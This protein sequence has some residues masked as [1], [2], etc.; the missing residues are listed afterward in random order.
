MK[1]RKMLSCFL[2]AA[3]LMT[4]LTGCGK[5][6]EENGGL[7]EQERGRY[8]E[9]EQ[10]LPDEWEGWTPKQLFVSEEIPHLLMVKEDGDK[11][12]VQEWECR[13]D[14]YVEVT[15]DWLKT[16]ELPARDWMEIQLLED[17]T[18]T[19][20]LFAGF[21]EEGESSYKGHLWRCDGDDAKDITPE[22]WTVFH[23]DWG[24]YD[25][26]RGIAAFNN[27][28]LAAY[29]AM[30]ID[31]LYGE[32]GSVLQSDEVIG[33]SYDDTLLSDGE[34]LYLL[35][36]NSSGGITEIE[37]R[38]EGKSS[39]T[40]GIPLG[41]STVSMSLCVMQDGTLI[42]AGADGIFRCKS[43]ETNWEK[44]LDGAETAFS[45]SNY[46]CI[47]VAALSDGS[48]YALFNH[49]DG[50]FSLNKYQYDPDAVSEVTEV[51]R[52]FT[53]EESFLLQNAAALYHRAHPE[54]LIELECA[55]SYDDKYSG[56]E[57]DYNEIYQQLNTMLMGEEAPDILV[58][59]HLD[60]DSYAEKGLLADLQDVMEPLEANGEVLANITSAYVREDGSRYAV[61]M[62]FGFT[63]VMG[64][65]IAGENMASMAALSDFL[66]DRTESYLGPRTVAEL[67]D[68]FYPYFCEKIV[69]E[70]Q[71]NQEA[72]KENLGYL[73]TIA[74]NSGV[75]EK[76]DDTNGRNGHGYNMW[77]L[78]SHVK[79]AFDEGNGFN[80]SMFDMALVDFI[81]G[82]FTA[83]ENCFT[84]SCQMSVCSKSQYQE[85]AKDF[86][87]FALSE[88]VQGTDYYSGFPV[89]AASME[90]LAQADR[91][92]IAACTMI[93][94]G[95]GA[96]EEFNILAYPQ[97]TADKLVELCGRL[98]RPVMEDAKI[99]EV[100]I[101]TLGG[102]LDG[103]K[104]LDETVSQIEGGL[105][106]YLAE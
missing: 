4:A 85:T 87:R 43:G 45:L 37:K 90:K 39:D 57:P 7:P 66:E 13:D 77:D 6:N 53:V 68:L 52:L 95:D 59:D 54:V 30:S 74:Q 83:F 92:D 50:S 38:K 75:V 61:P 27:G 14:M 73:K 99:R 16:L 10:Q 101:D 91:S 64:R 76:H 56:K 69:S 58:L 1:Y 41:Q 89:N 24:C 35:P 23:E 71:L 78:A 18:G 62:E 80:N 28:T 84:P 36:M 93:E 2:S 48:I 102:Y 97:E 3:L 22:K 96:E 42:S 20:Y 100:L 72:L 9:E 34:N 105:K 12:S 60:M 81:K 15:E 49:G 33:Y 70:G 19:Q 103:S 11:L 82:D 32:D 47:G 46:W 29:S 31:I 55:Y 51:L 25:I 104:N 8:V 21:V 86:I 40:E 79:L 5:G 63:F 88:E 98:D 44:L 65:E 106:M 67:V 94:V 26:V 17:G